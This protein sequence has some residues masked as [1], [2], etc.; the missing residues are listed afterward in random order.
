MYN[1]AVMYHEGEGV[2]KDPQKAAEWYGKASDAGHP[3]AQYN[4]G[5]MLLYGNE[6][7]ADP[8]KALSLFEKAAKAGVQDAKDAM[9]LARERLSDPEQ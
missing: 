7:P 2:P 3:E 4:L 5:L 8:Q 6:I 9:K 1:L